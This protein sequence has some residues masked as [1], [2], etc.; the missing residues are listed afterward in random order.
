M[1]RLTRPQRPEG[2]VSL[3]SMIDVLMIMVIF[4]MVTSTFLDLDM[5][6]LSPGPDQPATGLPDPETGAGG[7]VLVTIGADGSLRL[8]GRRLDADALTEALRARAA[9]A[10]A[11]LRVT[12][13]PA[14]QAPVQALASVMQAATAA[15]VA[16]L[17]ILQP[18]LAP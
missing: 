11:A 5:L 1:R 8:G 2:T 13:F 17:A 3:V 12:V 16:R 9:Q 6:P 15:G 14:G 18:D 10:P 4:F 7:A